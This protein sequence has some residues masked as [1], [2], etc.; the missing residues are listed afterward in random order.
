MEPHALPN[1]ECLVFKVSGTSPTDETAF[2]GKF[3][4][5]CGDNRANCVTS[6]S[7]STWITPDLHAGRDFDLVN[8][9]YSRGTKPFAAAAYGSTLPSHFL[10]G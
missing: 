3:P 7:M 2:V 9:V 1:P 6:R 10:I 8:S 5:I 4:A